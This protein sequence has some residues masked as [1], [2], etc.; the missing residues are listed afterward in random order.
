[1]NR[2]ERTGEPLALIIMDLDRFHE[3]NNKFGHIA[4]DLALATFANVLQRCTRGSDVAARY[5]GDEFVLLLAETTPEG[6]EVVIRRVREELR[7]HNAPAAERHI[8]LS[9]S[10][11]TAIFQKGMN[12][13]ALFREADLDLLRR[14]AE[15]R[16][17]AI[18][19][20]RD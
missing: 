17:T 19:A 12:F 11:G 6:A 3:L 8:P 14:K 1:M 4:G 20:A 13:E 7:A 16:G 15:G 18:P 9:F 5:G 2:A 10:A